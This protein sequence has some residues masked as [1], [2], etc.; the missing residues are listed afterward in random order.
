MTPG[1]IWNYV[2]V[3][4]NTLTRKPHPLEVLIP[5]L[6]GDV[7]TNIFEG[8][9]FPQALANYHLGNLVKK[10]KQNKKQ[11]GVF[12]IPMLKSRFPCCSGM[13]RSPAPTTMLRS[14]R[15]SYK[16]CSFWY[17]LFLSISLSDTSL[18]FLLYS[19]ITWGKEDLKSRII[20]KSQ[21]RVG[22]ITMNSV[23]LWALCAKCITQ[24]RN[25]FF[26]LEI[27]GCDEDFVS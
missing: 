7:V 25:F 20:S 18:Y 2:Q 19:S 17:C 11:D 23:D 9:F 14:L 16:P 22:A 13:S 12:A 4:P 24:K 15:E 3:K 27:A 8:F 5:V 10:K 26:Q 1:R 6:P 21:S